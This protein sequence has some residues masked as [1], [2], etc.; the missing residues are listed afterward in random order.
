MLTRY[1]PPARPAMSAPLL[2][3]GTT[4]EVFHNRHPWTPV[5]GLRFHLSGRDLSGVCLLLAKENPIRGEKQGHSTGNRF[6]QIAP[7]ERLRF[8]SAPTQTS[9]RTVTKGGSCTGREERETPKPNLLWRAAIRGC[10]CRSHQRCR[11]TVP[12][13]H[14]ATPVP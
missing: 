7:S 3:Q 6:N 10:V 1:S 11:S 8:R 4:S 13:R 5:P 12:A 2:P 9:L 14:T